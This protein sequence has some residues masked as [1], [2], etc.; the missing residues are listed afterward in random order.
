[1]QAPVMV[2]IYI[3]VYVMLLLLHESSKFLENAL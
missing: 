2:S 3:I 1:M